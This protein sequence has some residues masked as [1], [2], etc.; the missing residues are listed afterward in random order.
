MQLILRHVKRISILLPGHD[1]EWQAISN[2]SG[3]PAHQANI[4][5]YD[6]QYPPPQERTHRHHIPQIQTEGSEGLESQLASAL[7][8]LLLLWSLPS[9]PSGS[10]DAGGLSRSIKLPS[11]PHLQWCAT[12]YICRPRIYLCQKM[13]RN[14][15]MLQ[16]LASTATAA[17][18]IACAATHTGSWPTKG[19]DR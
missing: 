13:E 1:W 19:I 4:S 16:P 17:V 3:I 15:M 8:L 12:T 7:L 18:E 6:R 10:L 5:L 9:R 14:C 2:L 11:G